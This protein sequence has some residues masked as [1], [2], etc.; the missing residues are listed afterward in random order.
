MIQEPVSFDTTMVRA[1]GGVGDGWR[2]W[3]EGRGKDG[4]Y[5]R[6]TLSELYTQDYNKLRAY[7]I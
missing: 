2:G 4:Q 3:S 1:G 7:F 5:A 6:N